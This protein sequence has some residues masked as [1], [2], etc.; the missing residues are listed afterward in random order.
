MQLNMARNFFK[1]KLLK[2]KVP[3]SDLLVKWSEQQA[4]IYSWDTLFPPAVVL[5]E[6]FP[7]HKND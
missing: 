5:F 4:I 2:Q 6:G 7:L 1:P 3:A